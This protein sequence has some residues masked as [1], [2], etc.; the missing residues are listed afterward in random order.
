MCGLMIVYAGAGS[1]DIPEM[2]APVLSGRKLVGIPDAVREAVGGQ[3]AAVIVSHPGEAARLLAE[4]EK[5]GVSD[6][7][8]VPGISFVDAAAARLGAPLAGEYAVV[9]LTGPDAWD[10]IERRLEHA[11]QMGTPVVLCE[12]KSEEQRFALG[13]A[14]T[15][16]AKYLSGDT[17]VGVCRRAFTKNEEVFITTLEALGEYDEL[18]DA[19]SVVIVGGENTKL[20]VG[21]DGEVKGMVTKN[22]GE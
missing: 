11:F 16:A 10:K 3:E 12:P 17:H 2:F 5:A 14:I 20:W 8:V 15:V 6:V 13:K 21:N 9:R 1:A 18:I 22:E 19:R 7:L 4:A